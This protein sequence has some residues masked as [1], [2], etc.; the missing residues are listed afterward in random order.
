MPAGGNQDAGP[1]D[2]PS[3]RARDIAEDHLACKGVV[4]IFKK[5]DG[6]GVAAGRWPFDPERPTLLFIHGSGGDHTLWRGQI[7]ALID[8]ANTIALDLP[9]HG[10][11]GGPGRESVSDYAAAVAAL[12]ERLQLPCPIPCGLS[13]GGAIVLQLLLDWPQ[14]IAGGVLMGTG[15][16]LRV[17]PEILTTIETD[18]PGF[19]DMLGHF[20]ASEKTDSDLLLPIQRATAACAPSVTAGDFRAC[21]G[22]DVMARLGEIRKPVL[23]ISGADDRLTPP[24]YSDF[25]E[26]HIRGS[27]RALIQ[28][29]GHLVPIE[30]PAVVNRALQAFVARLSENP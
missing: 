27:Q 21:N 9:G 11:S 28:D 20:G 22:F 13:L 14:L 17:L 15:A 4:L 5:I 10:A 19:V 8:S 30:K 26:S 7:D 25:L 29:A 12:L 18:Y 23:V 2:P 1:V 3:H 6:V 16:R 24:K